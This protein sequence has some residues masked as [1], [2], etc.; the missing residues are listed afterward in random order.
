MK[1]VY[2]SINHWLRGSSST[3]L[4][5][6]GFVNGNHQFLTPP[7]QIQPPLTD[8]QKIVAGDFIDDFYRNTK[9]SA[10]PPTGGGLLGEQVKYNKKF[11]FTPS[12]WELTYRSDL[13]MDFHA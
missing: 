13:L 10:N 5:A 12:F 9:F 4:M 2:Q 8:L 3:V 6:T 11:L 7:T 1:N